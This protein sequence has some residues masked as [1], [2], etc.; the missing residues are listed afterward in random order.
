MM[1]AQE[2]AFRARKTD[3][4]LKEDPEILP[5]REAFYALGMNPNKFMCSIEA[6]GKRVQ[7]GNILPEINPIVDLGNA[8]SL[9]YSLPM[10]AHDI[11]K[12]DGDLEVRFSTEED[13]F[14]PMGETGTE[15]PGEGEL[16]YVSGH[17]VKTRRWIWRQS[18][19]GK[20]TE[21]TK[22]VFFPIDGF[23]GKNDDRIMAAREEL[24][25]FIEEQ[26]GCSASVGFLTADN[27]VFE[28]E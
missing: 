9:K 18:D 6:L 1:K 10:G 26:F 4:N 21:D 19:D 12:L 28:I 7:K 3:V 22:D 8:F 2:E 5:Y 14:L 20:I 11:G 27:N 23:I 17:T 16:V 15:K 13:T 25:Q 24:K